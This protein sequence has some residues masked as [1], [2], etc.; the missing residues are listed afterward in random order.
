VWKLNNNRKD[1]R[2]PVQLQRAMAAEVSTQ[3]F[4]DFLLNQLDSCISIIFN[5]FF[6]LI[7]DFSVAFV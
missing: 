6:N 4:I 3:N 1:V 5:Y 2:L 7:D